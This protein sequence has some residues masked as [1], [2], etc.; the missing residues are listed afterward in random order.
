MDQGG[1]HPAKSVIGAVWCTDWCLRLCASRTYEEEKA[2]EG[3]E[4]RDNHSATVVPWELDRMRM[5]DGE[6]NR[7]QSNVQGSIL[8]CQSA[9]IA[10][11]QIKTP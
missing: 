6:P 1:T 4:M 5:E 7:G 3:D 11:P 8:Y 10:Q 2:R 9:V